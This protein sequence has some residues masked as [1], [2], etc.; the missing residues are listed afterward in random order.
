MVPALFP[1]HGPA[2]ARK[3]HPKNLNPG[4]HIVPFK[5]TPIDPFKGNLTI[6]RQ[7]ESRGLPGGTRDDLPLGKFG[8]RFGHDP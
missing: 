7:E 5:G 6:T 3:L 4:T 8:F 2:T 1:V